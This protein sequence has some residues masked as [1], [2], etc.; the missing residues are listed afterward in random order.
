[1]PW[2]IEERKGKYCVI[3]KID[4]SVEKCHAKRSDAEDHMA[5]LY[6]SENKELSGFFTRKDADGIWNWMGIV[7]NNWQ[8]R[9]DEWITGEAHKEFVRLI[10]SGEY[11][12]MI[13]DSDF[14]EMSLFKEIGE[15]GTP[16]LWYWHIPVPIGYATDV[17]YDERGYLIAVGKQKEGEFYSSLFES[18]SQTDILHGM[19]HGMPNVF[20]SRKDND[21]RQ[22]TGYIDTEFTVMPHDEV[23][24]F[25]TAWATR[26]KEAY[27]RVPKDKAERMTDVFGEEAVATFDA[28]LG[29]LEIFAEESKIPRKEL[30]MNDQETAV[31]EAVEVEEEVTAEAEVSADVETTETT[32]EVEV[33][34]DEVVAETDESEESDEEVEEAEVEIGM[35]M[36]E[37]FRMPRDMASFAKELT[38]GLKEVFAQSQANTDAKFAELKEQ[39]E[40]QRAEIA[41]LKK[42]DESKIAEK[43]ADTPVASMAGWLASQ[44]GSVIGKEGARLKGNE[45]RAL[46]NKSTEDEAEEKPLVPGVPPSIAKMMQHQQGRSR[47]IRVPADGFGDN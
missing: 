11:G 19:S 39:L 22:I 27:M 4:N 32:E 34:G 14:A 40:K 20:L 35:G 28:L 36:S 5:A 8:D 30:V 3:K 45:E 38:D 44:V 15:R 43:A 1:M 25:G 24:N 12:Q 21:A 16:D 33:E 31:T 10:D 29:E 18:L 2:R 46:Y 9:H 17:A 42:N 23:A 7:S 41:E 6:A 26:L 37:E 47:M 13:L